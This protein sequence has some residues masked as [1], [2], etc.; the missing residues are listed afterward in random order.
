[1][2]LFQKLHADVTKLL[3]KQAFTGQK[4]G[5]VKIEVKNLQVC[6]T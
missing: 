5:Y 1:M 4:E 6:E 2:G 3:S